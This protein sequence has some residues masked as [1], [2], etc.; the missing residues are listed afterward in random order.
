MCEL[1]SIESDELWRVLNSAV[2]KAK[3]AVGGVSGHRTRTP[4]DWLAVLVAVLVTENGKDSSS[5]WQGRRRHLIHYRVHCSGCS[6][7]LV[8]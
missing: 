7:F 1:T 6:L 8:R 4:L 2:V 5:R 3:S